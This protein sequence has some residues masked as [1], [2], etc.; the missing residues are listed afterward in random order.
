MYRGVTSAGIN[1]EVCAVLEATILNQKNGVVSLAIPEISLLHMAK[2]AVAPLPSKPFGVGSFLLDLPHCREISNSLS[3]KSENFLYDA[4]PQDLCRGIL[5]GLRHVVHGHISS[6]SS[7][8]NNKRNSRTRGERLRVAEKPDSKPNPALHPVDPLGNADFACRLC[9]KELSNVYYHCDGCENLLSKDYNICKDCHVDKRFMIFEQ[10]HPTNPK[11]HATLN[12]TGMFAFPC[13]F[14]LCLI[15]N[16]NLILINHR[17]FHSF[18]LWITVRQETST[19]IGNRV[20]RVRM[21]Q[22]AMIAPIASGV[23]VD[24]TRGSR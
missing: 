14:L 13:Q 8:T 9:R 21:V 10:M 16:D 22:S 12:H 20:A 3:S 6:L 19:M 1:R 23:P 7:A 24:A 5:P 18:L 17:I 4:S 2:Q 11:R 15:R